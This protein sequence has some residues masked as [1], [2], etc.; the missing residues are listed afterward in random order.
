MGF[1]SSWLEKSALFP[2]FIAEEPD[3]K[4]GIII[5][6]PAYNETGITCL[7]DSLLRCEEPDCK[8]EVLIVINAPPDAPEEHIINNELSISNIEDWKLI[9]KP[10]FRLYEFE[11]RPLPGWGVGMARKSG[12]DEALRRFSLIENTNG[13]IVSLDADCTVQ[14]NYF[15]SI[16]SILLREKSRMACSIYFEHETS[17]TGCIDILRYELHLRYYVNGLIYSGFPYSFHTV[18]S[19]MA[20]KAL[21]YMKVG[22]MN[23]KQAGEDFYFIQKLAGAGDYFNLTATTVF[24]SSRSSSRVPFGTGPTMEKL[25]KGMENQ[26]L[27]YNFQAFNDLKDFFDKI[28]LMYQ[29]DNELSF[30]YNKLSPGIRSFLSLGELLL[31]I[32][33]IKKNTSSYESFRKRFFTWFNMFKIIKFMNHVHNNFVKK[34]PVGEASKILLKNTGKVMDDAGEIELLRFF[35]MQDRGEV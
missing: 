23:R 34:I 18:G 26:L 31:K 1:A 13:V 11:T 10:F 17:D 14:A 35:R 15:R 5:V 33:E 3:Y 19:A 8:V 20:V 32:T 4:T 2:Q 25:S 12:M 24:P 21:Q 29:T 22:G 16:E 9:N 6:V 30:E 7:L 27:T 28:P